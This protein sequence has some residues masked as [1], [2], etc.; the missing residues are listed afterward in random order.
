MYILGISYGYTATAALLKDGKIIASVSEERF[1]GKK[2]YNGFP[3]RSIDYCLQFAGISSKDLNLVATPY[4]HLPPSHFSLDKKTDGGH[5]LLSILFRMGNFGRKIFRTLRYEM[6]W[7]RPL[8]MF[9]YRITILASSLYYSRKQ[10]VEIA[11]YLEIATKKI[12]SFDHHLCHVAAAYY[13]SPFNSKK[14]LVFT[15]DGEGDEYCASV[16]LAN[17]KNIKTMA[18]TPREYSLGYIFGHVTK[19]LGMKP[20]EHEY[21]VMGLAP[22]AKSEDVDKVYQKISGMID[23]D[24]NDPLKFTMAKNSQDTDIFL[25]RELFE[26]RFDWLAAAFQRLVE[27]K[28]MKW[29]LAGINKT[30]ITTVV[31]SGGVFMNIKANGLI[32]NLKE[33]KNFFVLPS[34]GDE[35]GP[36]GA[37]Y[38]GYIGLQEKNKRSIDPISDLYLGPDYPQSQTIR[39]LKKT[40]RKISFRKARNIEVLIAKLLAKGHI[41]ANFSGR[42]EFGARALGN[43]SILANPKDPETIKMINEKIKNRD[44][45]M[46]FAPTILFE[47][48]KDYLINPK[49]L[50]SPYM[51][52]GFST[53]SLAKK[54]LKAALHP[55]DLTCRPQILER[56]TNPRYYR[57]IKEFERLTGIGAVL[58]TS[59][60]IHGYPIVSGP[61][62]AIA[63]FMNSGLEY[64]ALDDYLI[65]KNN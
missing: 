46:P 13:A 2:N 29:V 23:L 60:N 21:K 8:G 31:L 38:L 28:T 3:K 40:G 55:A 11:T 45:W 37:C 33:V 34:C 65:S 53:T 61:D 18:R 47:R 62:E 30:K 58:N 15:L 14:A 12:V 24:P 56:F 5:N 7:L 36:L 25:K 52:L 59:F 49:K 22:Y 39:A 6:P 4:I 54:D 63:A 44:F 26:S 9:V 17:G 20:H 57:I 51:M 50:K 10:K 27:Q 42:M 64:L 35:T 32:A 43:R 16:N 48:A 19:F 1:N 41:V